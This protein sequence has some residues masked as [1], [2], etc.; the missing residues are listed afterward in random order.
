MKVFGW[1]RRLTRRKSYSGELHVKS[2]RKVYLPQDVYD[3]NPIIRLMVS[4]AANC[5]AN[6]MVFGHFDEV[7]EFV[8]QK[9]PRPEFCFDSDI[10][11]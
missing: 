3:E 8:V 7:G 11:N 2:V 9:H 10:G 4:A 6:E 5:E 1:L